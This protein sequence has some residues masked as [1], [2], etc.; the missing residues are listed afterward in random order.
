MN[1]PPAELRLI[2]SR[3]FGESDNWELTALLKVVEEEV[4]VKERSS[5]RSANEGRRP[6]REHPTGVTLLANDTTPLCCFC[7][8]NHSSHERRNV[9]DVESRHEALRK[10]GRC[11]VCLQK[12]HIS[13]NCCSSNKCHNCKGKHH[14]ALWRGRPKQGTNISKSENDASSLNPEVPSYNP[15]TWTLWTYSNKWVLLQTAQALAD[16][17]STLQ[18]VRIVMDTSGIQRSYIT[19]ELKTEL[20][21]INDGE[22]SMTT[23]TFS[24]TWG[25][26]HVCAYMSIGLKLRNGE[27]KIL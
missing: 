4:Q 6:T 8:Q 3:T 26:K 25:E 1:K 13:R 23:M 5:S 14:T 2:A 20:A 27:D 24:S 15:P 19:D 12:V 10:A 18:R 22:Q 21:L 17:S 9:A 7:Q 11:F 16:D